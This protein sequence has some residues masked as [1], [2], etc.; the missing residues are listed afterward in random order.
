VEQIR[1]G[2]RISLAVL[3]MFDLGP[4]HDDLWILVVIVLVS[5]VTADRG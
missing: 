1:S 2:H 4:K 5:E 3:S